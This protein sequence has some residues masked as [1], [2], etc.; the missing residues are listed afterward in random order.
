MLNLESLPIRIE[1]FDISNIQGQEIVGSM[2][3]FE[4]GVAKQGALPQVRDPRPGGSGRLRGDG[5][6][7]RR[8]AS[9]GSPPA[10]S[11]EEY[12]ESFAATPNLV[13]IDGGKGQLGAALEAMA[14]LRPAARRGDR[15]RQARSRRCSCPAARS[16][17]L[18]PDHSPGLQL[19]QRIR[20]EAHRFAITL[21][22]HAPRAQPRASRCSTSSTAS[23]RRAAARSCATSARPSACSRAT[24]GG[25]R[26]RPR[27]AGEDRAP[28][29]RAAAP[30]RPRLSAARSGRPRG[31]LSLSR[32]ESVSLLLVL[33]PVGL[34]A[35][36]GGRSRGRRDD[37]RPTAAVPEP[38]AAMQA[39]IASEPALARQR[40]D[41]LRG[42]RLVG[43]P[44]DRGRRARARVRVP[45]RRRPLARRTA[46]R[47]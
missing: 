27:R 6:G 25:A 19:L 7:R 42:Q 36:C 35:G 12:D 32:R 24:A 2:V 14:G 43:R 20:D 5:R 13:V 18:L 1:C 47:A 10:S 41:A 3:V 16:R 22:P 9:R 31:R 11:A 26:G 39:L 17:S 37:A 45:P 21:P 34:L 46:S 28:D 4:D 44:V 30:G 40:A 33:A 15:A 8:A 38:V 29:L 23:A